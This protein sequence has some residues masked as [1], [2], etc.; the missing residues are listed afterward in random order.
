MSSPVPSSA[1]SRSR[2]ASPASVPD[3]N[4][5][6]LVPDLPDGIA[7]SCLRKLVALELTSAGFDSANQDAL[8]EL[9]GIVLSCEATAFV[10]S[11]AKQRANSSC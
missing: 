1:G 10:R 5:G 7:A 2:S 11:G 8:D 3:L 6:S 4:D 9:E